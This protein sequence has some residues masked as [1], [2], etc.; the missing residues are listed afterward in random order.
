MAHSR[1][2]AHRLRRPAPAPEG[3]AFAYPAPSTAAA[4]RKASS[5][6]VV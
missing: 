4:A 5:P 3:G 1:T 2:G 6:T